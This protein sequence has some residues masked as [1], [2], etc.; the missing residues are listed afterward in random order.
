MSITGW[1]K[2]NGLAEEL[3]AIHRDD[4]RTRRQ[5][6]VLVSVMF[7]YLF[8]YTGRQS[9]GFAI[10]G[11]EE[12]F[13]INKQMLGWISTAMLWSYAV[14]QFINGGIA[15][16]FG[17]RRSMVIGAVGSTVANW[18]LSF[19]GGFKSLLVPWAVN[20]YLQS[21]GWPGGSRLL[22]DWFGPKRLGRAFGFFTFSAASAGVVAFVTSI[23]VVDT[24][25]LDWRWI[26]RVPVLLMLLGGIVVWLLV[27]DTPT[28]ARVPKRA[29]ETPSESPSVEA[30]EG[31]LRKY[32]TVLRNPKIWIVGFC[33][34]FLS[35]G[36]YGLLIW[37]PV[38]FVLEGSAWTAVALPIGMAVG[39][40]SNGYVSDKV[41]GANRSS[42][43]FSYMAVGA[44]VSL[45]LWM[46]PS[47]TPLA[48]PLL[49]LAGLLVYG[50]AASVWALVPDLVG[51]KRAGT[52][53]GSLN[54]FAYGFAGLS[55]PAI[56]HLIDE[57]QQTGLVFLIVAG[58]CACSAAVA[59]LI[60]RLH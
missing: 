2:T 26:F 27:R 60:R 53:T 37:A 50:P 48:M 15:D 43:I 4:L 45:V 34:G 24:L 44:L 10:P 35:I 46:L 13:G 1:H 7:C 16:K 56:G 18:T 8:M 58:A 11:I 14:G 42:A 38:H 31:V 30:H 59:I 9:F 57:T 39:T 21:F 51:P 19:A 20:G 5:T 29:A 36:R 33:L 49:F 6:V 32:A 12:E 47:D 41:F 52:A 3:E 40:L 28:P 23:V 17:G 54:A 25:E 55:E 22:A